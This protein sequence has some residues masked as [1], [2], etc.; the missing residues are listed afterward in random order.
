[1]TTR[2]RADTHPFEEPVSHEVSTESAAALVRAFE[3]CTLP[4]ERWTHAAH[5]VVGLWYV[6][7][8]GRRRGLE[9]VSAGIQRYNRASARTLR[10]RWGYDARVTREWIERIADFVGDATTAELDDALL[11]RVLSS[12]LRRAG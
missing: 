12:F 4:R 3:D 6:V 1:M 7:H 9:A 8:L 2:G 10:E 11:R 5:L